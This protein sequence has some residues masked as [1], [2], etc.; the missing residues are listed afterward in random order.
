ML[1]VG[2]EAVNDAEIDDESLKPNVVDEDEG[3]VL[4]DA[5]VKGEPLKLNIVN[6][7]ESEAVDKGNEPLSWFSRKEPHP[8]ASWAT[9][10]M[11]VPCSCLCLFAIFYMVVIS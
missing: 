10:V 4:G 2:G 1:A 11:K 7:G 5:E 8:Q 3:R 9:F 6:K